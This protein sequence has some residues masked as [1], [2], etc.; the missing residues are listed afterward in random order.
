VLGFESKAA[1][2]A[3]FAAEMG[4]QASALYAAAE[5]AVSAFAHITG[6]DW[7]PYENAQ[8]AGATEQRATKAMMDALAD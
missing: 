6:D 5:G 2:A 3:A 7:K 4:L 1:R 8:P